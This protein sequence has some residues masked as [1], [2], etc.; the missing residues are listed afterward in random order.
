MAVSSPYLGNFGHYFF[1][2]AFCLSIC[3]FSSKD[4]KLDLLISFHESLRLLTFSTFYSFV[5]Q[6]TFKFIDLFLCL[7]YTIEFTHV[8][9]FSI[10]YFFILKFPLDSFFYSFSSLQKAPIFPFIFSVFTLTSWSI[11]TTHDKRLWQLQHLG[12]FRVGI[13]LLSFP[14]HIGCISLVLCISNN[15]T[16]RILCRLWVLL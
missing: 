13:Y 4:I 12:H 8:V 10:L 14:F 6:I 9:S 5:S 3:F 7:H 16:F 15:S 2:C 1:K 11:V